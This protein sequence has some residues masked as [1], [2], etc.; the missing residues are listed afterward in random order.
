MTLAVDVVREP[1]RAQVLLHPTRLRLLANL[2]MPD[3]AAGLARQL[4]LPRQRINYHLRELESQRLIEL[5][6]ERRRGSVTER[7][8]RRT[9]RA[10][11]L[12]PATLGPLALSPDDLQDTFSAAYLMA[13]ASRTLQELAELEEGARR[14]RQKLPTFALETEVRFASPKDR[15]AFAEEL[16]CAVAELVEKYH[17]EGAAGGRRFRLQCGAYPRPKD[18][19]RGE[20]G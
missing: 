1:Q 5:V 9:G 3:S 16:A 18:T 2:A 6:E 20:A 10:Y 11:A 15:A 4:G 13:L 8:Y 7:L 14:A 17:D 19:S 12:S